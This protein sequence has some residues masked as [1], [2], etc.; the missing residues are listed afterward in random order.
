MCII[1]DANVGDISSIK[2]L[3]TFAWRDAYSD[4][5]SAETIDKITTVWHNPELFRNQIEDPSSYFM[6]ARNETGEVIGLATVSEVDDVTCMIA[7][8]FVRPD[9]QKRGIG[10]GLLAAALKHFP[11]VTKLRVE[12][13]DKNH[14]AYSFYT[15]NGFREIQRVSESICN[16]IVSTI[17]MEKD[18]IG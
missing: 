11:N 18:I 12:V 3:L 10:E 6:V 17:I 13:L 2:D 14:K 8:H 7:R 15:K 9:Y 5:L 16:D 4:V 1:E